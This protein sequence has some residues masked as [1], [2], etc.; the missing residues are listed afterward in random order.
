[1][2]DTLYSA[3]GRVQGAIAQTAN[4]TYD[5]FTNEEKKV[6]RSIFIRLTEYGEG[7]QPTRRRISLDEIPSGETGQAVLQRL[8][9][10]RLVVVN[11]DSAEVAHEALIHEWPLL[12]RWL[13]ENSSNNI[14]HEKL[15][16]ETSLWIS[17]KRASKHLYEGFRLSEVVEYKKQSEIILADN[18]EEFIQ[19]SLRR[20]SRKRNLQILGI[21]FAF[22][23]LIVGLGILLRINNDLN[24]SRNEILSQSLAMQ[25]QSFIETE[26]MLAALLSV[27]AGRRSESIA[28]ASALNSVV[29]HLARLVKTIETHEGLNYV[30]WSQDESRILTVGNG[31]TIQFWDVASGMSGVSIPFKG[32]GSDVWWNEQLDQVMTLTRNFGS[33]GLAPWEATNVLDI[34]DATD[35]SLLYTLGQVAEASWSP[36]NHYLYIAKQ[37]GQAEIL[38]SLDGNLLH[39]VVIGAMINSAEW[40]ENST[41]LLVRTDNNDV[42]IW[43]VVEERIILEIAMN[44]G[45]YKSSWNNTGDRIHTYTSVVNEHFPEADRLQVWQAKD[46]T[47]LSEFDFQ[48]NSTDY[49][50]LVWNSDESQILNVITDFVADTGV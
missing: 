22:A 25:A 27:E 37:D 32:Y 7:V 34:W 10:D 3:T 4:A 31:N 42:L 36:N 50:P 17:S 6:A 43:D 12:I 2:G 28:A 47:L 19:A 30:Q 24:A 45:V 29:P 33:N 18:E 21:T 49:V 15:R 9:R 35:G 13:G 26:P 23:A 48:I 20:Q 40:N 14:I 8:V 39:K 38:Y 16:D 41:Q 46:G 5:Q 44:V 1:M 11:K